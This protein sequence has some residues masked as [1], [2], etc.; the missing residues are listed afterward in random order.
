MAVPATSPV[1]NQA[2][3]LKSGKKRKQPVSCPSEETV[4][5]APKRNKPPGIRVVGGRIYDSEHGK[6]CHQC[7]Q[8]TMDFYARCCNSTMKKPCPV[9]F[10]L[11]CLLN[12]YGENAEEAA[13]RGDWICPKCRGICNC[14]VCM[15]KRGQ[16]PTGILVH[17][18]KAIGC[19][20]VSEMLQLSDKDLDLKKVKPKETVEKR[21]ESATKSGAANSK[22]SAQ[23]EHKKKS[24]EKHTEMKLGKKETKN[25]MSKQQKQSGEVDGNGEEVQISEVK[26][27][28][29]RGRP[30]SEK[31]KSDDNKKSSLSIITDG[32]AGDSQVKADVLLNQ[33]KEK[34]LAQIRAK[35]LSESLISIPQNTS[36]KK[37]AG[38]EL[39]VQDVGPAL[40]FLEFCSI[41]GKLLELKEG[42]PES[43][44]RELAIGGRGV[45][46]GL[47]SKIVQFCIML[48][49]R[50]REE[51]GD[52]ALSYAENDGTW[53]VALQKCLD[54]SHLSGDLNLESIN[55]Y[56]S[57]YSSLDSSKKLKILNFLC[58]EL[59][60]TR[61]ARNFMDVEKQREEKEK[62][63]TDKDKIKILK[64]KVKAEVAQAMLELRNSVPFSVSEH[65]DLISQINMEMKRV[66]AEKLGSSSFLL[67]TMM[68]GV[69]RAEPIL[70][71]G[72]GQA[73]WK[74]NSCSEL[75]ILVQDIGDWGSAD[76][77]DK[78]FFYESQAETAL[79][80]YLSSR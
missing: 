71:E 78:W 29:K 31:K 57:G 10:C 51:R 79:Q 16:Q 24:K 47:N 7:R 3:N 42:Q 40:Q 12:R 13:A 14:S 48:L 18:A 80:N 23:S 77:L 15:K 4:V 56:T 25:M 34:K 68:S 21:A 9:L 28:A 26:V 41:F 75:G 35:G 45:R 1:K 66:H 64:K 22:R 70:L 65:L 5:Q 20:S 72:D 39:Q 36:L 46:R 19:S 37:V 49:S 54:E 73:F 62:R 43:I 55:K 38:V 59:L 50:I 11:K 53:L 58:D 60:G 63:R 76:S 69:F 67:G 52:E 2:S 44:L 61:E 17:T 32:Q 8:K 33:W 74:L 27:K 30:P 6:T